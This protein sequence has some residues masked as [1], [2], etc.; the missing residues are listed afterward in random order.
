MV[1]VCCGRTT[2]YQS[3]NRKRTSAYLEKMT[4]NKVA[5]VQ[6]HAR[7]SAKAAVE[8]IAMNYLDG[9]SE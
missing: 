3:D 5:Q 7:P 4:L 6:A 8:C 9:V 1:A 2:D